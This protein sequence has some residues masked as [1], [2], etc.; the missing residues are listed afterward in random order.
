MRQRPGQTGRIKPSQQSGAGRIGQ[1][2]AGRRQNAPGMENAP[3]PMTFVRAWIRCNTNSMRPVRSYRLRKRL[4]YAPSLRNGTGSGWRRTGKS[5]KHELIEPSR[6]GER[7]RADVLRDR[8]DTLQAQLATIEADGAASDV[9]VA[10]LTAELK[11][12]RRHAEEEA[13]AAEARREA[14]AAARRSLGLVARLRAA[15]RGE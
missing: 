10:E 3:A 1:S 11:E 8:L 9:A 14:E 13:Q 7:A 5:Q 15:W 4:A 6:A 12:A 2:R